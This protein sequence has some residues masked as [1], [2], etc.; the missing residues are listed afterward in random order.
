MLHELTALLLLLGFY[1]IAFGL[2]T[3]QHL[4]A[5]GST[6]FHGLS[7][8]PGSAEWW[9][10]ALFGLGVGLSLLAPIAGLLGWTAAPPVSLPRLVLGVL[11]AVLGIAATYGAQV[12]MGRSWRIGVRADE[13]TALVTTGP[14]TVVRNPIF[15]CM[16][17]TAGALVL[18]LP[19]PLTLAAAASL[20]L[21]IELQV[22]LVEEPHLQRTHG[23]AYRDY[24]ARVGRFLPGLGRL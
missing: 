7:G 8:R 12:S 11:A 16:L 19:S 14:F 15:T 13:R 3:Y 2:R 24:T 23:A 22:R 18:L 9:G 10:G 4:R 6:G 21:A 20:F 1:A 17:W 5:T